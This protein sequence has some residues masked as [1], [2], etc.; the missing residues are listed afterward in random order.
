MTA[1]VD[2]LPSHE[3]WLQSGSRAVAG[4]GW[5]GEGAFCSLFLRWVNRVSLGLNV[6]REELV[7]GVG[8]GIGC[9]VLEWW[10]QSNSGEPSKFMSPVLDQQPPPNSML[11]SSPLE[12]G[13]GQGDLQ[14]GGW[15]GSS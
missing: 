8:H 14:P 10:L 11:K 15:M 13:G 1:K 2:W 5:A 6:D 7:D 9:S 4:R 12:A 3:V